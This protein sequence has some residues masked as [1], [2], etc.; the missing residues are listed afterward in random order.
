MVYKNFRFQFSAIFPFDFRKKEFP[1]ISQEIKQ[2]RNLPMPPYCL[3]GW[4]TSKFMKD[5]Y[6][7]FVV[8]II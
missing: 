2:K 1:N 7:P 4:F 5:I 8:N 6:L 3:E